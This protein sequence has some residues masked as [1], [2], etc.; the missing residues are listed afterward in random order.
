MCI[1]HSYMSESD[2][3]QINKFGINIKYNENLRKLNIFEY[4]LKTE[5]IQAIEECLKIIYP[6]VSYWSYNL[7][8][9]IEIFSSENIKN[10][11]HKLYLKLKI[12][13]EN[14][15]DIELEDLNIIKNNFSR[16]INSKMIKEILIENDEQ[17]LII[18]WFYE[19][20]FNEKDELIILMDIIIEVCDKE[21][22]NYLWEKL[23]DTLLEEL[24][25]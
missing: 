6:T 15:K 10:E 14:Y 16:K 24:K 5:N 4:V 17:K 11:V 12:D 13:D 20:F 22:I 18:N 19:Y 25:Y 7:K 3:C 23:R 2:I 8:D 21:E 1:Y 9:D